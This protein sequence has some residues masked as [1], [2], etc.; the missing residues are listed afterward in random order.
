[1]IYDNL[2]FDFTYTPEVTSKENSAGNFTTESKTGPERII[3]LNV[4]KLGYNN[5]FSHTFISFPAHSH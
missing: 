3:G 2:R 1:M 5:D 4:T